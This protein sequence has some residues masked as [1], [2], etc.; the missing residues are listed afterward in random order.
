MN[1]PAPAE[2]EEVDV[3]SLSFWLDG[4]IDLR[5]IDCREEDEYAF[6]HIRKGELLPLSRFG[7]TAWD[8]LKDEERP[9]VIY[10]HHGGRSLRATRWLRSKGLTKVFSLKGG[11]DQWSL[12]VDSS[13]PRY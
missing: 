9:V 2:T 4:V 5:L 6:N 12:S 7:E 10:C 3:E 13:V 1:L 11:I 8:A